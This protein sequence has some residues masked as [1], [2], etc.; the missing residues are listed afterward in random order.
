MESNDTLERNLVDLDVREILL[1]KGEPFQVIMEA[2]GSLQSQDVLQLHTT[3]DPAPLKKVL[4]KQ[5]FQNCLHKKSDD[6]FVIQFYRSE[7][8]RPFWHLD[9]RG[10]EPPQPM[11]RALE[12]LDTEDGLVNGEQGLEIWNERV[13]AFLLPELE[14]RGLQFDINDLENGTVVVRIYRQA[15]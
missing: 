7:D 4:G 1:A 5:G 13:P 2:I 12:W 10:L 6:H 8:T 14:E 15:N 11:V 9:N 3:F